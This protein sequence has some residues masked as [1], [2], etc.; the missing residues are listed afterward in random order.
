M[1]KTYQ[2]VSADFEVLEG[3]STGALVRACLASPNAMADA[4][5]SKGA[6]YYLT[7]SEVEHF[8]RHLGVTVRFVSVR[9]V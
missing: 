5:L 8:R 3:K 1:R 2:V 7:P 6:W 9:E 4:Y